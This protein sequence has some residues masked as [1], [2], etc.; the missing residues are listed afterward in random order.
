MRA[1]ASG[2]PSRAAEALVPLFL[3]GS[4]LGQAGTSEHSFTHS[5][6]Q[7]RSGEEIPDKL[8]RGRS[9]DHRAK[10]CASPVTATS[11]TRSPGLR[12][13]EPRA[14]PQPAGQVQQSRLLAPR[15]HS[16]EPPPSEPLE[17]QQTPQNTL[18]G[19][20]SRFGIGDSEPSSPSSQAGSDRPQVRPSPR[21]RWPPARPPSRGRRQAPCLPAPLSTGSVM[22]PSTGF[23]GSTHTSLLTHLFYNH[24]VLL[25]HV[26]T[27]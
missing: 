3:G 19:A 17:G 11:E 4:F 21:G 18:G 10:P 26:T 25:S 6:T 7:A 22:A 9:T 24:H 12:K 14:R 2:S 8:W 1:E 13:A 5:L 20:G 16:P 23:P 27:V 15:L